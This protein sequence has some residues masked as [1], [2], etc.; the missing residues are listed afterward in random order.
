MYDYEQRL[1]AAKKAMQDANG[2]YLGRDK[3]VSNILVART[4]GTT[5]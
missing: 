5:A 2:F 4:A 3:F 1:H